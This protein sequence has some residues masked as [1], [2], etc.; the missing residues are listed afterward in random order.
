MTSGVRS[1]V[2]VTRVP[3]NLSSQQAIQI[4]RPSRGP[5]IG[6]KDLALILFRGL[7]IQRLFASD[8]RR[9]H[10]KRRSG[11]GHPNVEGF[12]HFR[13]GGQETP[14]RW[15]AKVTGRRESLIYRLEH[16][17]LLT[18]RVLYYGEPE[19]LLDLDLSLIESDRDV[20][21]A[22]DTAEKLTEL[23]A[24]LARVLPGPGIPVAGGLGFLG[25]LLAFAR[26]QSRDDLELQLFA[27]LGDPVP[28]AGPKSASKKRKASAALRAGPYRITRGPEAGG[29]ADLT[30]AFSVHRAAPRHPRRRALVLLEALELDLDER[31]ANHTFVFEMA[32]GGGARPRI[33]RFAE[34]LENRTRGPLE[35]VLAV[36]D[37]PLYAGFIDPAAPFRI[38]VATLPDR[39]HARGLLGLLGE[40][41]SF[42]A[43]LIEEPDDSRIL[44]RATKTA[45][46]VA[47][48]LLDLLPETSYSLRGEGLIGG[49]EFPDAPEELRSTLLLADIELTGWERAHVTLSGERGSVRVNLRFGPLPA[50]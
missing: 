40:Q 30:I 14:L 33:F 48:I 10:P 34:T 35:N 28:A 47:S 22:L 13:I 17:E 20:R 23:A 4:L 3:R 1:R 26:K 43:S 46:S 21:D 32:V 27:S 41:G 6:P 49:A 50:R 24:G 44:T 9:R 37:K 12:L 16:A 31:L 29:S 25:A 2:L 38:Q 45:E 8:E 42:A 39:E 15:S 19:G 5:A 11:P 36:R 18:N 7:E